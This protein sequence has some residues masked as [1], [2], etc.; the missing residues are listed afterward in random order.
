MAKLT[1]YT[2]FKELKSSSKPG[3]GTSSDYVTAKSE[4]E[5]FINVLKKSVLK[6]TKDSKKHTTADGR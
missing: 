4:F 5:Q 2:S 6:K 1:R 3:N